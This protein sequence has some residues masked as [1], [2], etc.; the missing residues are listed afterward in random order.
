MSLRD[1]PPDVGQVAVENRINRSSALTGSIR[2]GVG[3]ANRWTESGVDLTL[4]GHQ[5]PSIMEP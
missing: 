2:G 5:P 4:N 1:A 3:Q